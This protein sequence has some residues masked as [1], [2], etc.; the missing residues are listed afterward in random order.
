MLQQMGDAGSTSHICAIDM[1]EYSVILLPSCIEM[2]WHQS[3]NRRYFKWVSLTYQITHLNQKFRP[4]IKHSWI[5]GTY[6][7]VQHSIRVQYLGK[8]DEVF[9]KTYHYFCYWRVQST[10]QTLEIDS[11]FF[12]YVDRMWVVALCYSADS[13]GF[14]AIMALGNFNMD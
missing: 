12:N 14:F 1:I 13:S 11:K 6:K 5:M 3:Q 7:H 2:G 8:F 10:L 9:S 4:E